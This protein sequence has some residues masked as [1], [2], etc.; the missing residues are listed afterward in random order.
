[1]ASVLRP[2]DI[3]ARHG[4]EEFVVVLPMTGDH[5]IGEDRAAGVAVAERIRTALES[6]KHTS[7]LPLCTASVGVAAARNGLAEAL[8]RAD[9]ALYRAKEFGRNRVEVDGDLAAGLDEI[10]A[11]EVVPQDSTG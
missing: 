9:E 8:Q 6:A 2:E 10:L 5:D 4:G 11:G 1:M 3:L 7:S